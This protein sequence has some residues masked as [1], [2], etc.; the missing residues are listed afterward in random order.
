MMCNWDA[1]LE[2]LPPRMR[3]DTDALG[4]YTLQE[5]RLRLDI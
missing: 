1:L 3:R 5:L 4:R 2:I